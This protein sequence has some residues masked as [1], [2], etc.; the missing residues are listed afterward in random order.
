MKTCTKC[1]ETKP[2]S[3]FG[4]KLGNL[5]ARC[6]TCRVAAQQ[7]Y[8]AANPDKI[9]ANNAA[10]YAANRESRRAYGRA[11][12]KTDAGRTTQARADA[13]RRLKW[14]EKE[15]ARCA[16]KNAVA[17]YRLANAADCPCA[18]C[19][20]DAESYHHL[21]GYAEAHWL[22]VIPLCAECHRDEDLVAA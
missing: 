19:G 18:V 17:G 10:H 20:Y 1:G 8:A 2:A 15:R 21:C 16:V 7:A 12:A 5:E 3:G 13:A 4:K 9:K 6:R 11:Y 22:D 14:P